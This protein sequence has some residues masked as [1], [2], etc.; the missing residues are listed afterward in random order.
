M[1][2]LAIPGP[3]NRKKAISEYKRFPEINEPWS[4][5]LYAV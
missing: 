5:Y 1:E 3:D 4:V 2:W